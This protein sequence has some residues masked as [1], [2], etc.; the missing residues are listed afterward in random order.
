MAIPTPDALP[1]FPLGVVLYPGEPMPLHIFEDR[2]Q[3]MVRHCLETEEPFGIVLA[4]D[5]D[6]ARIG[7]TARID[8]VLQRYED[9]RMDILT[10]GEERFR[11]EEVHQE[12]LYLT[13][14]VTSFEPLDEGVANPAARERVITLHMKLLE[15]AGENIRPVI[16]EGPKRISFVVAQN[17]G[18]DLES[19]QE[20]LE[21]ATEEER[22]EYLGAH[23]E[24]L[25]P[26][27]RK[28][29][30]RNRRIQSN[31]HLKEE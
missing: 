31:G 9:G 1:L 21:L 8:R 4:E 10:V 12:R 5:Q 18:L 19:K 3:A 23:L 29:R 6:L 7:C 16:Y 30:E 13:A 14:R 11:I 2:Y 24:Q 17:A 15:L 22:L 28:A 26:E 25:I 27:V 20:V